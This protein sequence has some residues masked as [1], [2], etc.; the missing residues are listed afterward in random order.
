M[1]FI[2][3]EF[4]RQQAL[5]SKHRVIDKI[6][7]RDPVTFG[8]VSIRLQ[9]VL[10]THK[11]PHE[12]T[13]IHEIDLIPEEEL[14]VLAKRRAIICLL[15]S[16]VVIANSFTFDIGPFFVS[17]HM[18]SLT[19][20]HAREEHT[21][22]FHEHIIGLIACDHIMVFLAFFLR[23]RSILSVSLFLY[24]NT[25]VSFYSQL[26][27]RIVRL[28]IEKRTVAILLTVE[29]ILQREHIIGAVLIHRCVRIRTDHQSRIGTVTDQ[30]NG[31]HQRS[32]VQPTG[33]N[34]FALTKQQ[35]QQH[36][37]QQNAD[38]PCLEQECRSG[39]SK[40]CRTGNSNTQFVRIHSRLVNSPAQCN[41][42][43][44]DIYGKTGIE[45][46]AEHVNK[47]QLKPTGYGR[48]ARYNTVQDNQQDR[49]RCQER[50]DQSF[51]RELVTTEIVHQPD[52]RNR[53]Q[54][55]QVNADRQTHQISNRNQPSV[56]TLFVCLLVP[57][58]DQPEND[59]RKQRRTG[60]HF[61]FH[62]R[63]P[64][65][66]AKRVSQSAHNTCSKNSD[67]LP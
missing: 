2:L 35:R 34:N 23:S 3:F 5:V 26:Y 1:S 15:L 41:K 55:Q 52:S 6:N 27:R 53:Q 64:E 44:H 29:I 9:I 28:T 18:A 4:S 25:H 67:S 46:T 7:T 24:R 65:R 54:V 59:S 66:V 11:V 60:I 16:A 10:T 31:N 42:S 21:E 48:E 30:N 37:R 20:I 13:P 56:A 49:T 58:Q 57:F 43:Q 36:Y 51:P 50:V 17:A 45:R 22:L 62:S 33:R 38:P 12:V 19:R 32:R 39:E 61:S 40:R 63:E 14:Q 8:N 47:Q